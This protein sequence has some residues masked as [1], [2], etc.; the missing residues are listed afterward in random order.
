MLFPT[1]LD[2]NDA[3][4]ELKFS[5]NGSKLIEKN[6]Q[7]NTLQTDLNYPL[8]QWKSTYLKKWESQ[9]GKPQE[10]NGEYFWKTPYGEQKLSFSEMKQRFGKIFSFKLSQKRT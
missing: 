7:V 5:Q 4:A 1:R 8:E 3:M 9:Y 6:F 10:R 2:D